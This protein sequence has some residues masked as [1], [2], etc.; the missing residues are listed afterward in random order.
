MELALPQPVRFRQA[1][2][3]SGAKI[4][5]TDKATLKN[6]KG[7]V[8]RVTVVS[9]QN[10]VMFTLKNSKTIY[11]VNTSDYDFAN[12]MRPNDKVSFKS[13]IVE[14]KSIGNVADFKDE[15]LR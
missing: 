1:L 7:I 11:T 10:K 6:V 9:N 3:N 8:D 4:G 13:N 14:K 2:V 12:L 5:N 15:N